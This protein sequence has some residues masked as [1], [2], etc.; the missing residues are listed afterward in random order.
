MLVGLFG[1]AA[2]FSLPMFPLKGAHVMGSF[3]GTVTELSELVQLA[4]NG[5]VKPVVSAKYKLEEANEVLRKL[6][7]GEITGRAV[8]R[9]YLVVGDDDG[10][11]GQHAVELA[12]LCVYGLLER[13]HRVGLDLGDDVVDPI[14][15]VHSIDVLQRPSAR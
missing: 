2:S 10:V 5:V 1:G 6:G 4:A 15:F 9:P 13:F 8:L 12:H 14:H 11:R 3:T 7:R